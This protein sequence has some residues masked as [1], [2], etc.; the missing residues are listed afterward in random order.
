MKLGKFALL[1]GQF[2]AMYAAFVL[3]S[4][5][6]HGSLELLENLYWALALTVFFAIRDELKPSTRRIVNL[7]MFGFG[8]VVPLVV[9]AIHGYGNIKVSDG[10]ILILIFLYSGFRFFETYTSKTA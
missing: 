4:G 10:C 5:A 1:V 8:L 7:V 9:I 6:F 2:V 3:L